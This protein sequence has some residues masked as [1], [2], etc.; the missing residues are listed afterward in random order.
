MRHATLATILLAAIALAAACT[1]SGAGRVTLGGRAVAGPV[2]PVE[3]ASPDPSCA[4]RPVLGAELVIQDADGTV[5]ARTITDG[6]GRFSVDLPP[7]SYVIVPQAVDGL[8]GT[9]PPVTVNA[10]AGSS[11]LDVTLAYDTGIR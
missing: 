11:L 7:G 9:A 8:M 4:D 2:C 1:P 6:D 5:V 10:A 3:S